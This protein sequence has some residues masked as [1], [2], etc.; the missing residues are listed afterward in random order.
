MGFNNRNRNFRENRN[1]RNNDRGGNK[2]NHQQNKKPICRID[3]IFPNWYREKY[4]SNFAAVGALNREILEAKEAYTEVKIKE[5]PDKVEPVIAK[6]EPRQQEKK[7]K[8]AWENEVLDNFIGGTNSLRGKSIEFKQFV[9]ENL[10]DTLKV[11][12]K[13][14]DDR[15]SDI[16]NK[17]DRVFSLL[18]TTSMSNIIASLIENDEF[19]NWDE[20]WEN[21]SIVISILISNYGNKI[22]S[23]TA[24]TTYVRDIIPHQKMWKRE[25]IDLVERFGIT[26]ELATDLVIKIPV[27]VDNMRTYDLNQFYMGFEWCMKVHARDNMD[28]LGSEIQGRLFDFFFGAVEGVES[29]YSIA[30][31]AVSRFLASE[32]VV[33]ED[34]DD[35]VVSIIT[36]FRKMLYE[37]LNSFDIEEIERTL[38]YIAKQIK[39]Q[40]DDEKHDVLFDIEEAIQFEN[41][42]QAA[43]N[44]KKDDPDLASYLVF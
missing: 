7:Q 29:T 10:P 14:L 20:V 40:Q 15:F 30:P 33:T 9:R 34:D 6:P 42:V 5:K 11:L 12:R 27:S 19:E 4:Y 39:N 1:N 21:L 22:N 35:V 3:S 13:C 36:A 16:M 43:E 32:S 41:I 24:K 28:I 37:K 8:H 38:R 26:E 25:I 44:L 18:C 17:A 31:K 2:N 23:T